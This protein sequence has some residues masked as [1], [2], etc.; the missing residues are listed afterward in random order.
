MAVSQYSPDRQSAS[1]VHFVVVLGTHCNLVESQ[2]SPL[3]QSL[4]K[5]HCTQVLDCNSQKG[6]L[7]GHCE[8]WV[9]AL[10]TH[11]LRERSQR[12]VDLQSESCLHH[13]AGWGIQLPVALSQRGFVG[14]FRQ[15]RSLVHLTTG[16]G[17]H[18]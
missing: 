8:F 14:S 15:S 5:T 2:V 9:Q 10:G 1:E 12:S 7:E 18:F 13:P 4:S 11:L 17:T 6:L 16:L 3:L